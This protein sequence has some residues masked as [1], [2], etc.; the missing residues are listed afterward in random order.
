MAKVDKLRPE[1]V[2]KLWGLVD[3]YTLRGKITVA[4]K[5]P[6]KPKPPYT[7]LQAEAMAVFALSKKDIKRI[8]LHIAAA[9][10]K[11]NGG[12]REQWPDEFSAISMRY[13]KNTR[14]FPAIAL[15]Y[16]IN[17]TDT[18]WQCVWTILQDFLD[19]D[20]K[21]QI[22]SLQTDIISKSDYQKY[23]EPY[24]FTLY[25]D[26]GFRLVAPYILLQG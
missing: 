9:W 12:K 7:L 11:W 4:R 3:F 2:A 19:P 16:Q 22:F 14:K 5:W 6:R 13:W 24:F 20:E 1:A 18:T 25:D 10:K 17:E 26:N 23:K 21:D 15:D 8:S